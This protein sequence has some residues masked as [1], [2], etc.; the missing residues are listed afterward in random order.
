MPKPAMHVHSGRRHILPRR[1]QNLSLIFIAFNP[2]ICSDYGLWR[3]LDL[4]L[5]DLLEWNDGCTVL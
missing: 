3:K 4:K 2:I 5:A 1:N